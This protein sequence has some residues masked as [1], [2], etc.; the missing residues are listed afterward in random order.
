MQARTSEAKHPKEMQKTTDA[1]IRG[2]RLLGVCVW[3][4]DGSFWACYFRQPHT[5]YRGT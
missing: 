3:G 2:V 5:P 1:S 4:G